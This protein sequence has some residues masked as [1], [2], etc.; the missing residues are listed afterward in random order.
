MKLLNILLNRLFNGSNYLFSASRV[1]VRVS[2]RNIYDS[3][4]YEAKIAKMN[5]R[6]QRNEAANNDDEKNNN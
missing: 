5:R 3:H 4:Y 2:K 6:I 1:P